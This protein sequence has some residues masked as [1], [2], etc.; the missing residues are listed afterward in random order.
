MIA[1]VTSQIAAD[2]S[3]AYLADNAIQEPP[4]AATD[5]TVMQRLWQV[6]AELTH[7]DVES[8]PVK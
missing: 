7:L 8:L 2:A 6:S 5:D 3:G 4:L 1:L